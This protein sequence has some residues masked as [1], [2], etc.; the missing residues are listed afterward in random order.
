ML[1]RLPAVYVDDE[2]EEA[3]R[4]IRSFGPQLSVYCDESGDRVGLNERVGQE[5]SVIQLRAI[6]DELNKL[7]EQ[8][9]A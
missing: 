9:Q 7:I 8:R 3:P 5:L 2:H 4:A 6:V 1:P